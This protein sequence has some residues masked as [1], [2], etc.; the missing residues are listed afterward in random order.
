MFE[1]PLDAWYV[2]LGLAAVSAT[3]AGVV[4][5]IPAAPPPDATGAA[6][7]VDAVAVSE[8]ATI[9]ERPLPNA[10]AVRVGADS[11]SLRGPGGTAHARFGYGPVTPATADER[12]EAVLLGTPPERVFASP[13]AFERAAS[14]ARR[15]RPQWTDTD[16][17]V[18][19][20][21]TWEGTDVVL[22]G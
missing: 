7:T 18:V 10:E 13:K 8:H 16:R 4:T 22:V 9:D 15:D 3:A 14:A 5:A 2:W 12:L 11:L 17:L 19:R 20:R 21:V 1:A 6:E